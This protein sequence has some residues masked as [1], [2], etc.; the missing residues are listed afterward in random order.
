[1]S[2]SCLVSLDNYEPGCPDEVQ[3]TKTILY[4]GGIKRLLLGTGAICNVCGAIVWIVMNW[5]L[6]LLSWRFITC[7]DYLNT[8]PVHVITKHYLLTLPL[9]STCT[10]PLNTTC[11]HY[12]KTLSADTYFTFDDY[13]RYFDIDFKSRLLI[14]MKTKLFLDAYL[15]CLYVQS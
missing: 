2:R 13:I 7:R 12:L 6:Y 15:A 1:M 9:N 3:I 5:T 4:H 14:H 10:P 11:T 8:L